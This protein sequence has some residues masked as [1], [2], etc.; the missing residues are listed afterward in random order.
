MPA[1][2]LCT[3][4]GDGLAPMNERA[5]AAFAKLKQGQI[6]RVKVVQVRNA[7]FH[8]LYWKLIDTVWKNTE[9]IAY[10]DLDDFHDAIKVMAGYRRRLTLP[11]AIRD[12]ETGEIIIPAG[13]EFFIPKSIAFA[14]M[15]QETFDRFFDRVADLITVYFWPTVTVEWLR[16]EIAKMLKLEDG[17][18]PE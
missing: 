14:S 7:R 4:V 9:S 13:T 8:R 6:Y 3:K 1:D 17:G 15:T 11:N 5:K 12:Q 16:A 18:K 2:V 10:P